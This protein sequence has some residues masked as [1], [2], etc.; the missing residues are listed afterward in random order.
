MIS[1]ETARQLL[2]ERLQSYLEGLPFAL[3]ADATAALSVEGKLL[4]QSLS[5]LDGRWALLPLS[6]AQ[7]LRP[8][9]D[10]QQICAAAL[11]ME[12]LVCATDLLDD[13]MDGDLT[14]LIQRIGH[15][16]S[17]N[18]A[19]TLIFLAQHMLL[20][21]TD[22]QTMLQQC[23]Q[24]AMLHATA[25]QQEDLLAEE[26]E[27]GECDRETCLA[28]C[29]AKAGM[30]LGLACE[31]GALCAGVDA[32]QQKQWHEVGRLLGIAA[33]LDNDA[34]DLAVLLQPAAGLP[35][36]CQKSDL[37]RSKKTL[38]VVLAA[39]ALHRSDSLEGLSIDMALRRFQSLTGSA[40]ACCLQALQA[41]V[42]TTWGIA[43]LYRARAGDC[44]DGLEREGCH[45]LSPA[46]RRIL[47]L[48]VNA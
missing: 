44:L 43:H 9:V 42:V 21:L 1:L 13:A 3:Q 17:L 32:Q 26:R 12:C 30:L 37:E 19:L 6:L 36:V 5:P 25:G 7:E 18:T 29:S 31:M 10:P 48:A 15:A 4:C 38:P 22:S 23:V 20:A 41:G 14:P 46:L 8:D 40:R 24:N 16:R 34:H 11:A 45:A 39:H 27:F 28:I 35:S 47:G 33:Q 2:C